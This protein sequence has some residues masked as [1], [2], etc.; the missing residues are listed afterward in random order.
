M[1]RTKASAAAENRRAPP[2]KRATTPPS[3]RRALADVQGRQIEGLD[4]VL[5]VDEGLRRG[6]AVVVGAGHPRDSKDE[7]AADPDL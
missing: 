1:R 2:L 7:G 5:H 3:S 4:L 6:R